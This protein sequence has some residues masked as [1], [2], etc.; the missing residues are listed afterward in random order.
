MI[1]ETPYGRVRGVERDGVAAFKGIRYARADRYA[2]PRAPQS[3][4]GVADALDFGPSCPQRNQQ[5]PGRQASVAEEPWGQKQSEDCL[6]LNIWTGW[7]PGEPLRPVMLWLHG[8]GFGVGSASAPLF[9]GARLAG[10]H[11]VVMASL[12]HR[13]GAFGFLMLDDAPANLGLLDIVAGLEWLRDAIAAFGGDPERIMLFGESGGG[14]KIISL[15]AMPAAQGLFHRAAVQS[16]ASLRM[17]EP[18]EGREVADRL[19]AALG[20]PGASRAAL[21]A[22]E[23]ERLVAAATEAAR[24]G[25]SRA[26]GF[27]NAF[28]PV[29]DG[30]V[31]PAHP[32]DPV[33]P[34]ISAHVPLLIGYNNTEATYFSKLG[35]G[36]TDLDMTMDGLRERLA[37]VLRASLDPVVSAFAKAY[38][39]LSPWDLY[40]RIFTEFPSGLFARTVAGRRAAIPGS[41]P[42]FLYRFDWETPR[43]G[44]HARAPHMI[45]MPF[46]FDNIAIA[47]RMTG[48]APEA[49]ALAT[50]VSA[51]WAEFARSGV[52]AASGLPDWPAA[53]GDAPLLMALDTR[54]HVER[55]FAP[56][57]D[58]LLAS[59]L[60]N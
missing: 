51:A 59:A 39:A 23:P 12:N 17:R 6:F 16:G 41:A 1:V 57:L 32:F 42:T 18:A 25:P 22:V 26:P 33:A 5:R 21:L 15:L 27:P 24:A 35:F 29:V 4:S 43:M 55:A 10:G 31:I 48:D 38:P 47:E 2:L 50:L 20:L 49:F 34:A 45:E 13:L 11:D 46:V 54:C 53:R 8:G 3:W 40:I 14:L 37:R 19:A 56:E 36:P 9:D 7:R 30:T 58:R 52:P 60:D 28:T 44:G